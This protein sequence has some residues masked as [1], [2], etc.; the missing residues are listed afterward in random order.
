MAGDELM[1]NPGAIFHLTDH[2]GRDIAAL[3]IMGASA[4]TALEYGYN[5]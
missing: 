3:T 2:D 1:R 5:S 4:F